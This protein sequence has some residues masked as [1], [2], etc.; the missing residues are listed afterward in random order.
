MRY[1]KYNIYFFHLIYAGISK[2]HVTCQI[3]SAILKNLTE[4]FKNRKHIH[5]NV[6]YLVGYAYCV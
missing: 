5:L 6:L 2:M 1:D 3:Y 4:F